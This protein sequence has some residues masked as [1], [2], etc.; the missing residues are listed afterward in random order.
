MASIALIGPDG[1]GKTTICRMLEKSSLLPFKYVYM[2]INFSASNVALPTTRFLHW[3]RS[4]RRRHGPAASRDGSPGASP[5]PRR[6]GAARALL[7]LFHLLAEEWF[8]GIVSW[9]YERRG[10]VVLY[11]RHFVFDFAAPD[12]ESR[13]EP[14]ARRLHRSALARFYPR[15]DLVILLDA[16]ADVLFARKGE[17]TPEV[18][19][20]R[21]KVLL[22]EAQRCP[23]FVRVDVVQPV[24]KVYGEVAGH[25]L[26]FCGVKDSAAAA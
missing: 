7:R 22:R 25:V 5:Q 24:E 9:Y 8:R 4:R 26:R 18:L 6:S 11:D 16:P 14:L 3:W 17:F 21:R 1:S 20:R 13:Q 15:P 2:G 12:D 10:F 19:D 23:H